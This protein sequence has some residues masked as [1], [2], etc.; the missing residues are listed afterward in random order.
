MKHA[1]LPAT[2]LALQTVTFVENDLA[3]DFLAADQ[4]H[5]AIFYPDPKR[6]AHVGLGEIS[7][8]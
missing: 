6:R 2:Y 3:V 1:V 7:L 5:P 8:E 4:V